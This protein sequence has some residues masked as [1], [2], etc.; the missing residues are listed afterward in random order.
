MLELQGH[1]PMPTEVRQHTCVKQARC[2]FTMAEGTVETLESEFCLQGLAVPRWEC[3]PL[4]ATYSNPSRGAKT[5][6]LDVKF[7][8]TEIFLNAPIF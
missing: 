8:K 6:D 3:G 5:L 4:T 1:K 7:P 2:K